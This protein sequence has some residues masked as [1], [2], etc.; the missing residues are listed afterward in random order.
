MRQ[1]D[2]KIIADNEMTQFELYNLRKDIGER[3]NLA[4]KEPQRLAA[5]KKTLARL[6]AEIDA[7]GPKWD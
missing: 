7:E 5:M 6:H 4:E 1:G 2:Y 3:D